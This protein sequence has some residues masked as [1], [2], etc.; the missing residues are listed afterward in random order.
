MAYD[1]VR[2]ANE[3]IILAGRD[4][5][6]LTNLHV[7]ALVYLAD[8][9]C[10]GMHGWRITDHR[11]YAW[12]WGPVFPCLYKEFKD[13]WERPIPGPAFR[14]FWGGIPKKSPEMKII[15][16]VWEVFRDKRGAELAAV[17]RQG[18]WEDTGLYCE[19]GWPRMEVFF[20]RKLGFD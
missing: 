15:R 1:S 19:I 16:T 3:F 18:P 14:F 11:C 17:A 8:G 4:G 7:Q 6:R 10:L 13:Y 2:I 20:R 9:F 5:K 12:T